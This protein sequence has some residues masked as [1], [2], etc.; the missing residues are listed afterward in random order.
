M[1]AGNRVILR[2][3]I[4]VDDR[5]DLVL[6]LRIGGVAPESHGNHGI[7]VRHAAKLRMKADLEGRV[8]HHAG[9]DVLVCPHGFEAPRRT[10]PCV[11][12]HQPADGASRPGTDPAAVQ[13]FGVHTQHVVVRRLHAG[14]RAAEGVPSGFLNRLGNQDGPAESVSVPLLL[15]SCRIRLDDLLLRRRVSFVS[16]PSFRHQ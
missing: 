11:L 8:I 15:R 13:Q 9:L 12:R 5:T 3:V 1:E 14:R 2:E 10:A 6:V 4:L 16:R 7:D